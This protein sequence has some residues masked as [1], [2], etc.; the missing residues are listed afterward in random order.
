MAWDKLNLAGSRAIVVVGRAP[1]AL[2]SCTIKCKRHYSGGVGTGEEQLQH[3]SVV[4]D[5]GDI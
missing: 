3:R 2:V 1:S 5:G 4:V